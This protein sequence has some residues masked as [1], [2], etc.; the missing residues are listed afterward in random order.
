MSIYA[1]FYT[2]NPMYFTKFIAVLKGLFSPKFLLVV[3]AILTTDLHCI[4]KFAKN[5]LLR[6]L[7]Y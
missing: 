2:F 5:K 4:Y 7:I 3:C 1:V 6:I